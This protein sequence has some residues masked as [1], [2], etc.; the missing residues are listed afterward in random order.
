[1]EDQG[2]DGVEHAIIPYLNAHFPGTRYTIRLTLERRLQRDRNAT[3]L[4]V[5]TVF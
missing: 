1:V 2:G 5:G 3:F 4:E